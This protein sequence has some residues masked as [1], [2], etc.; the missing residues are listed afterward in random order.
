MADPID[1]ITANPDTNNP[2]DFAV[3]ADLAWVQL[4]AAIPQINDVATAMNINDVQDTSTTSNVLGNGSKSFEV[5]AGKSWLKGQILNI[6]DASNPATNLM[7]A[8]VTAYSG[9]SLSVTVLQFYG[10][11]GT[12]IEDWVITLSAMPS[13][14]TV[15]SEL[16]LTTLNGLGS[17]STKC[18]LFTAVATNTATADL[19]YDNSA[20][21]AT[22]ITVLTSGWYR[23]RG[24]FIGTSTPTP[25]ITKN[26]SQLTT[27]W[28]SLTDVNQILVVPKDLVP[29][30]S[31]YLD[32]TVYL[33]AN[34]ILRLQ[35]D[36]SNSLTNSTT[37]TYIQIQKLSLQG[38]SSGG[39]GSGG[40]P[41]DA[42]YVV[43]TSNGTLT[44]ER[45]ATSTTSI[46]ADAGTTGQMKYKR[47]ALIGDVTAD[48]D[49]NSLTIPNNTITNAKAAQM[50]AYTLKGNATSALA[51]P[52]DIAVPVSS[53]VG[54]DSSGNITS[55]TMGTNMSIVAGA[56]TASGGGGGAPTDATYIVATSNGTLSAERV[57]TDSTSITKN[58]GTAGQ[59]AFERAALT[60]DI[61]ASANSNTTTIASNAVTN[62]KLAT[63]TANTIKVNATTG[64]ATP[65]DVFI[66]ASRL[67]GRDDTGN[68]TG[69]SVGSNM[70]L[71]SGVLNS[72]GGL[73]DADLTA[74]GVVIFDGTNFKSYDGSNIILGA[75]PIYTW[76]A[77]PSASA[78]D[79]GTEIRINTSSFGGT[80][81]HSIGPTAVSD[82]TN[83]KPAG[84][85]QLLAR[86][87]GSFGTPL[88]TATAAVTGTDILFNIA[89]N[90]SLPIDFFTHS[91]V[92]SGIMIKAVMMKTGAD[93][94]ASTFRSKMGVN[95]TANTTDIIYSGDTLATA[96][97]GVK[98]DQ[99][100]RVTTLGAAGTA[101]FTTGTLQPNSRG[102]SLINDKSTYLDTPS[103]NYIVFT[104]SGTAGATHALVSFEIW[105]M[106]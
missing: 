46:T 42:E 98:I 45:V 28:K 103:V 16:K 51:D 85:Q 54:R 75:N 34:D 84:G 41:T 36:S 4:K 86:G 102:T 56:L 50:A 76:A 1:L 19:S 72:V 99:T 21:L 49:S 7:T 15:T 73:V 57:L 83:W 3:Q 68:I 58:V 63:M 18:Y 93:A 31:T 44:N 2:T 61:T 39:S 22:S 95:N 32:T 43:G 8:V 23:I 26:S 88:A 64:I 53:V 33:A 91:G 55:L 29:S 5:S 9:T 14:P 90:F 37:N 96:L 6:A 70:T 77:K 92:G 25:A 20:T 74:A 67:V 59:V 13:V 78:V 89:T 35:Q 79:V 48:A 52:Q 101:V 94:N 27:A 69:I 17:T 24:Q 11:S 106:A 80:Y 65:T 40:A 104:A 12:T 100:A 105:W 66:A 62:T 47:A 38:V 10:T 60:G 87:S 97:Q 81:K 71:A 82:G 30:I